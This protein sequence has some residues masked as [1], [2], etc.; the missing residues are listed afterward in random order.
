MKER[1]VIIGNSAAG[2][3]ALEAFRKHDRQSQVTLV[4]AESDRIYSRCLLSY[5]VAGAVREEGLLF[6]PDDYYRQMEAQVIPRR[7][8]ELVDPA[9]QQ[10]VCD[11]GTKLDYDKLLIATGGSPKLPPNIPGDVEG[12]FVLRTMA[13][14]LAIRGKLESAR[15]AVV[16]GG[17]LVGMKAAFGL[18]KRGLAVTVVVQS[19]HV[20]S[21][22]IDAGA[23]ELV[24]D[25]L[26][27]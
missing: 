2:I 24:M 11:D 27:G 19:R 9:G 1:I 10:I 23:A 16:L 26:G 6:R 8:V 14:A 4:S 3:G 12:V 5:F 7:K 13:D 22:M 18:R 17:G 15:N 21:Q 25:K 20:L